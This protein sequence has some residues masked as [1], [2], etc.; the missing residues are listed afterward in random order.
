MEGFLFTAVVG[1]RLVKKRL[2]VSFAPP[3]GSDDDRNALGLCVC[4][5]TAERFEQ[6]G[7]KFVDSGQAR[8]GGSLS[9]WQNTVRRSNRARRGAGS[10]TGNRDRARSGPRKWG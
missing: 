5:S 3:S 1:D 9:L 2:L 6:L 8:P 10:G 4:G 7:I